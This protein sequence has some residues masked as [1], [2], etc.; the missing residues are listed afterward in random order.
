MWRHKHLFNFCHQGSLRFILDVDSQLDLQEWI[1]ICFVVLVPS[2]ICGYVYY[3]CL[4]FLYVGGTTFPLTPSFYFLFY[5]TR[6]GWMPYVPPPYPLLFI[7]VKKTVGFFFY[8]AYTFPLFIYKIK[9]FL[10]YFITTIYNVI[11]S[12][13]LIQWPKEFGNTKTKKPKRIILR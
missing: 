11:F 4:H 6:R 12:L 5:S 2:S 13:T 10:Y 3:N 8:F 9:Y 7:Y 1:W